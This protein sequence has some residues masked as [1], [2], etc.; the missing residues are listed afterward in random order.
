MGLEKHGWGNR[1]AWDLALRD[2]LGSLTV[3]HSS[4]LVKRFSFIQAW[5]AMA[6]LVLTGGG[7]AGV[8]AGDER[9]WPGMADMLVKAPAGEKNN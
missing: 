8:S 7:R 6:W 2:L 9:G 1:G 3:P 4:S 5:A